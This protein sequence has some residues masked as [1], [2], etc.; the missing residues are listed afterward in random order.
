[1][2]QNISSLAIGS[3]EKTIASFNPNRSINPS[4]GGKSIVGPTTFFP[5]YY[6]YQ[7]RKKLK[8]KAESDPGEGQI[9]RKPVRSKEKLHK[10]SRHS[11]ISSEANAVTDK[12]NGSNNPKSD[13]QGTSSVLMSA[14][15][16]GSS[17]QAN[18]PPN[19]DF[20]NAS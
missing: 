8:K 17:D 18:I 13:G 4:S 16:P 11:G 9:N 12:N 1:V 19:V 5:D 3:Q 10:L 20:P 14:G 2:H 7:G 6:Q 15:L